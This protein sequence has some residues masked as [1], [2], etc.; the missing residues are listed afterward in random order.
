MV[1][2]DLMRSQESYDFD[3][4]KKIISSIYGRY[5]EVEVKQM[6]HYSH[7]DMKFSVAGH[8][9]LVEIKERKQDME[10]YHDIPITAKKFCY[11]KKEVEDGGYGAAM[12]FILLNGTDY[13]L[14]NLT[15]L[16]LNSLGMRNWLIKKEELG[17]DNTTIEVPTFFIPVEKCIK[18]GKLHGLDKQTQEKENVREEPPQA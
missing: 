11:L 13:L 15:K 9:A 5:G 1:D 7:A 2:P 6:P 10:K 16:D 3:Q 18:K 12:Y 8:T 4:T 17:N 14:F